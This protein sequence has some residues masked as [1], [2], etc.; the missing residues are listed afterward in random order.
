MVGLNNFGGN[1]K[2]GGHDLGKNNGYSNK[3]SRPRNGSYSHEFGHN[4]DNGDHK[5][6]NVE[7]HL[8]DNF[9]DKIEN[10]KNRQNLKYHKNY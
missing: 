1:P 5:S 10:N 3:S 4:Y 7:D 6:H 2:G 9:T 8:F